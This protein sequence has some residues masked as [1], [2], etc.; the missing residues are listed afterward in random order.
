M[1]GC[2]SVTG[3]TMDLVVTNCLD[4]NGTEESADRR[5]IVRIRHEG[6]GNAVFDETVTVPEMSCSDVVDGVQREDVFPEAGT[7][8][9]S[10]TVDGYDPAE[11]R[12]ELSERAIEDNSDNVVITIQEDGIEI[13]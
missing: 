11:S 7:Y 9:V 2:I 1:A 13:G 6:T 10:V 5:A 8:T 12:V 3:G 4:S